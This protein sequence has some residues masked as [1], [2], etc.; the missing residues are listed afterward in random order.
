VKTRRQRGAHRRH[1]SLLE[2]T[3]GLKPSPSLER[4]N[5]Q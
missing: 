1:A 3:P 2:A 5:K 4:L